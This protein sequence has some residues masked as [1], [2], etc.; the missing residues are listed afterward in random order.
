MRA[1]I[2]ADGVGQGRQPRLFARKS[3][4]RFGHAA[5]PPGEIEQAIECR[6]A[7]DAMDHPLAHRHAEPS[8][9]TRRA[10]GSAMAGPRPNVTAATFTA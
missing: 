7:K 1:D 5:I 10:I 3:P 2:G 4:H 9:G 8:G 6:D